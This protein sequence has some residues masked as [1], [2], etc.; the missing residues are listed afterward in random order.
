MSMEVILVAMLII[1]STLLAMNILYDRLCWWVMERYQ[2]P[3]KWAEYIDLSD[4]EL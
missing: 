1:F 2:F 3:A 4:V